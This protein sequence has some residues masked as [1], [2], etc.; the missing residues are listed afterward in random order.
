[1]IESPVLQELLTEREVETRHQDLLRFLRARFGTL[2]ED[3]EAAVKVIQ[4]S[5]RLEELIEWSAQCPDLNAFRGR[6]GKP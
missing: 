1:M 2:P 6:L 5:P 3:L 4:Q